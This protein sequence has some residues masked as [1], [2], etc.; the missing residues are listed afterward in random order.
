MKHILIHSEWALM[1]RKIKTA[2]FFL[3]GFNLIQSL[4]SWLPKLW[5]NSL[6][7]CQD[8]QLVFRDTE[9]TAAAYIRSLTWW[10]RTSLSHSTMYIPV[11]PH[12][13]SSIVLLVILIKATPKAMKIYMS[14]FHELV[15]EELKPCTIIQT[16]LQL[17]NTR[18]MELQNNYTKVLWG[19]IRP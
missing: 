8:L 3:K 13:L 2:R 15:G 6:N 7:M 4:Q 16:F 10:R 9:L 12:V 11:V 5:H 18:S 17:T 19:A 14:V 1:R